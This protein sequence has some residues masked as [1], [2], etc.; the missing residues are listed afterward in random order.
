MKIATLTVCMG[1]D[2]SS[3]GQLFSEKPFKTPAWLASA[4]Q[5]LVDMDLG[6]EDCGLWVVV[7]E[8]VNLV[9]L[10]SLT[11]TKCYKDEDHNVVDSRCPHH[12]HKLL[13][14]NLAI[15]IGV[16]HLHQI[17]GYQKLSVRFR[18]K[19]ALKCFS[20]VTSTGFALTKRISWGKPQPDP[21]GGRQAISWP[22]I[23]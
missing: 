17:L 22:H 16:H 1:G 9:N 12:L 13:E 3:E 21:A 10:H 20:G 18:R 5:P 8:L 19:P 4:P 11:A 7:G 15:T 14:V 2:S 23:H 6:K